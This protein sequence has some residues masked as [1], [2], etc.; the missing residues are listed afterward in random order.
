MVEGKSV[1]ALMETQL[2]TVDERKW[3]LH[4][5]NSSAVAERKLVLASTENWLQTVDER[6]WCL[7]H[8]NSSAVAER[9]LVLA[10]TENWLQSWVKGNGA[11]I[12]E[13]HLQNRGTMEGCLH[14]DI[15]THPGE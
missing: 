3:C 8:G 10:L 5:G 13:T 2:Q 7:H 14:L 15:T 11:C 9:K 1:L 4:H 12:M 6:K